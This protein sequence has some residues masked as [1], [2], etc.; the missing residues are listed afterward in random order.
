MLT[1][2]QQVDK[3]A[4]AS[5]DAASINQESSNITGDNAKLLGGEDYWPELMQ[6]F[7]CQG[8]LDQDAHISSAVKQRDNFRHY[9]EKEWK[10]I[11]ASIEHEEAKL[12]PSS[13]HSSVSCALCF[14][15]IHFSHSLLWLYDLFLSI[16]PS[17][18]FNALYWSSFVCHLTCL[19]WE[20]EGGQCV[21]KPKK[22][23]YTFVGGNA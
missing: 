13:R 5:Q 6:A 7:H 3:Q 8:V 14:Y 21:R 17:L 9:L 2:P 11:S 10:A 4:S 16:P 12:R 19:C 15:L 18:L 1:Y 23:V 20:E 22:C